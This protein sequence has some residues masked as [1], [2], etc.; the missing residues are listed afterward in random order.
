MRM[1]EWRELYHQLHTACRDIGIKSN[2][3]L[4]SYESIHKAIWTGRLGQDGHQRELY[5]REYATN[6]KKTKPKEYND[7]RNKIGNKMKR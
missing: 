5:E 1:R 6:K 3:K 7:S 2:K 4:E